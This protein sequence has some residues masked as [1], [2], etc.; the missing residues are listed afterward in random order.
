MLAFVVVAF[1]PI[2]QAAATLR[3]SIDNRVTWTNVVDNGPL[4][5]DTN[6]G[7]V[8]FTVHNSSAPFR[9]VFAGTSQRVEGLP[10]Y[11]DLNCSV[12]GSANPLVVQ[13]SDD[14]FGPFVGIFQTSIGGIATKPLTWKTLMDPANHLFAGTN[15]AGAAVVTDQFASDSNSPMYSLSSYSLTSEVAIGASGNG[16]SFDLF[17]QPYS[18][19]LPTLSATLSGGGVSLSFESESAFTYTLEYKSALSDAN[20]TP[21]QSVQGNDSTATL[22]D[23]SASGQTRFYRLSVH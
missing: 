14:G 18:P 1:S 19:T 22:V 17:L 4:D 7:I 23:S 11:M 5:L 21:Q 9:G 6:V 12:E 10:K 8:T 2:V 20:W 13:F 15:L 3:I 16:S